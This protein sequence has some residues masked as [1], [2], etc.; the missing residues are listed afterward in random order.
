MPNKTLQHAESI[1]K[2]VDEIIKKK[3]QLNGIKDFNQIKKTKE[4][5]KNNFNLIEK[6]TTQ[7]FSIIK[8]S[9]ENIVKPLQNINVL[10]PVIKNE[11]PKPLQQKI[12]IPRP[13]Q[14]VLNIPRPADTIPNSN[15][16]KPEMQQLPQPQLQSGIFRR[17]TKDEKSRYVKELNLSYEELELF[18]KEKR[19]KNKIK[20]EI[21][22][23]D[24]TIYKPND[25]GAFANK[26]MKKHADKL[27]KKYPKIFQPLFDK[28]L[29]VEMEM[30]SRSYVS[31][32]LLFTILAF[33]S[34]FIFFLILNFAFKLSIFTVLFIAIIG[35][36]GTF[37]GFYFY[38]ASLLGGKSA[39]IKLELPFAL[40][41]MSA[42]AGSGAQPISIFELIADSKEYPELRK[43]IK[44]ILN[45]TNLFGYNLT[46]ALRNVA[47][48]TPSK[49][50]KELLNGM[51]STIETGG[52]LKDYLK[53]KA[54]DTLNTY[55]LD[56]KKQVEALS[57]YSEVYTALLIA[58]PLLLLITFAIINSIGWKIAGLPVTTAAWIGILGF[59]PLLNIGFMVFVSSS[60]KGL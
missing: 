23:P 26:Y 33:P 11:I 22:E 24:Y 16:P 29:M 60:Q 12:E 46:N 50:L 7:L 5:I 18:V 32:M 45:Y 53:E 28:F 52:D 49:E 58:S 51:I 3:N 20:K 31:L 9:D 21:K 17:L 54:A 55:K 13:A 25:L 44:K 15:I 48:T 39:S 6:E 42:V 34:L 30:I 4:E 38:P 56:R 43:E 10:K 40:V 41:H 1:K 59:L 35:T 37:L 27:V 14:N 2:I 57:T 36:V 8:I 47:A 19:G